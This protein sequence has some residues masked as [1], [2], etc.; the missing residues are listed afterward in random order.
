MPTYSMQTA[1]ALYL[2]EVCARRIGAEKF[3]LDVFLNILDDA[4]FVQKMNLVLRGMDI[5]V[6]ILRSDL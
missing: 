3:V 4:V 1:V 6:Y 2:S 5:D